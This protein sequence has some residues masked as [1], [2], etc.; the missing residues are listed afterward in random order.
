LNA[1][2]C[3]A[4]NCNLAQ[5]IVANTVSGAT[6]YEFW[7]ENTSLGYSQ[8]RQKGNGIASI[9]ISW[10]AGVQYGVTYQVRVR[11]YVGGVWGAYGSACSLS[12][13]A[14]QPATQLTNCAMTNLTYSSL[15]VVNAVS[16]AQDYEYEITNAQQPLTT[17]RQRGSPTNSIAISWLTGIQYG[18]T[19]NVR[20]RSKVGGVW[21]SYGP[22]CTFSMQASNPPTQLTS[23]SCGGTG[24][25]HTSTLAWTAVTGA[26]NYR[27]NIANSSLG[28]SQTKTKGGSGTTM[29]LSTFSGLLA[30]QTYT[31]TVSSYIGG[32]WGAFGPACTITMGSVVRIANPEMDE[33]GNADFNF[34]ISMYPNPIGD[35]VNPTINITGADQR[36]AVVTVMDLTGRVVA[37]YQLFVDSDDYSTELTNFPDLVA[38]M[39]IMQVQV[40]SKV[41]SQKFVAE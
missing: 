40:G 30:N 32:A 21:G 6:N 22:T 23:P 9:G 8:T 38:G 10:I 4:T 33:N 39:Y 25:T 15:L 5:T 41:Q 14:Q 2:W 13:A 18:R 24:M 19:Y 37:T 34:G 28:Y 29:V 31:V 36:D 11:A 1:T 3:G 17:T 16:G 7:F 20:V 35:G 26:T 12:M 27:V